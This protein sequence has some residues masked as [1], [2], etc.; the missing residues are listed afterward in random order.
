MRSWT[1]WKAGWK[2]WRSHC[3]DAARCRSPGKKIPAGGPAGGRNLACRSGP[4]GPA[5]GGSEL[6]ADADQVVPAPLDVLERTVLRGGV[7]AVRLVGQVDALEEQ[8]DA[9][10]HRAVAEGVAQLCVQ[11]VFALDVTQ[12][13]VAR[14][15]ADLADVVRPRA[16]ADAGA[17]AV[18]LVVR[19]EVVH[20][21][22]EAWQADAAAA[23]AA[24][25]FR[26]EDLDVAVVERGAGD[27]A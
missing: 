9:L 25:A 14:E 15:V 21:V 3:P 10:E 5:R 27:E 6:V 8:G 18:L 4:R 7:G 17:E 20:L 1:R 23:D 12:R 26:I 24:R 11:L 16:L 22:R 2:A 19:R 13:A